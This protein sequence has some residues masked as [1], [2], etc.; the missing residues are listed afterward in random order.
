M[1]AGASANHR[2]SS[3]AD[4]SFSPAMIK[5]AL[6]EGRSHAFLEA[7]AAG[8]RRDRLSCQDAK[9]MKRR[10]SNASGSTTASDGSNLS[11]LTS[12]GSI[13]GK[14][15]FDLESVWASTSEGSKLL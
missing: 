11:G 5:A 2:Q 7:A 13:R 10:G 8:D 9:M 15:L 3:F 14:H 6:G 4:D 1:G 12:E